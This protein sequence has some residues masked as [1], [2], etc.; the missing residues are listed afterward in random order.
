MI[1]TEAEATGAGLLYSASIRPKAA[2][3]MDRETRPAP[4]A[5]DAYQAEPPTTKC[6]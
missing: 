4:M 1:N 6:W 2:A 5:S 3:A